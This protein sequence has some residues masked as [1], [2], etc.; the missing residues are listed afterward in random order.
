MGVNSLPKTVTR[1][2]RGRYLN[3]GPSA[4]ESS[5]LTTRLPSHESIKTAYNK[6]V[7][8]KIE[9]NWSRARQRHDLI[10][11][12]ETRTVGAQSVRAL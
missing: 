2:R 8:S 9:A 10:G 3:P 11:C 12:S 1:Q 4:P 6:R 5:T 7:A